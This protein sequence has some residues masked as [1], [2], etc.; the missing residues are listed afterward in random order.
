LD[1]YNVTYGQESNNITFQV[2]IGM[3]DTS[4]VGLTPATYRVWNL[5][6]PCAKIYVVI[7]VV[8]LLR[9]QLYEMYEL[10]TVMLR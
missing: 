4:V 6:V 2:I 8:S 10:W 9:I 3:V 7:R 1:K 5:Y